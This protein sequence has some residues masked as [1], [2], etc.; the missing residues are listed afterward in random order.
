[1][2]KKETKKQ[3]KK[4]NGA[5]GAQSNFQKNEIELNKTVLWIGFADVRVYV[6]VGLS[7]VGHQNKVIREDQHCARAVGLLRL[8]GSLKSY[9][10]FAECCLFCRALLQ[11]R[12]IILRSRL[13]FVGHRNK[14]IREDPS[15]CTC[16]GVASISRIDD[17]IGLFCKRAL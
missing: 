1:L 7:F 16:Y 4:K 13:S 5:S 8:V 6:C 12:P 9:V 10:S 3:R 14:V 11:K 15:L 17:I 2:F